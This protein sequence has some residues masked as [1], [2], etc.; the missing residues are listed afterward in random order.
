MKSLEA[1]PNRYYNL[2]P[3][4]G[5]EY[6]TP[7]RM[8]MPLPKYSINT[9]DMY[10]NNVEYRESTIAERMKRSFAHIKTPELSHS[11]NRVPERRLSDFSE[12]HKV[13]VSRDQHLI[14]RRF[15]QLKQ[16]REGY[17]GVE[18]D[19][20]PQRSLHTQDLINMS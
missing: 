11:Y 8:S 20:H 5:K 16:A 19:K 4:P 7:H 14:N 15:P 1:T 12:W 2:Q 13:Y 17:F 3:S 10:S 18:K 6:E 9:T